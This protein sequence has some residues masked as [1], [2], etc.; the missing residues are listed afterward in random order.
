MR[1]MCELRWR[2]DSWGRAWVCWVICVFKLKGYNNVNTTRGRVSGR[3]GMG[4]QLTPLPPLPL[5]PFCESSRLT[6]FKG[7][8]HTPCMS[9]LSYFAIFKTR[10]AKTESSKMFV[11]I[12]VGI[13]FGCVAESGTP[14]S[15]FFLLLFI[16]FFKLLQLCC[17]IIV[18]YSGKLA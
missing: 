5:P 17:G 8:T 4:G 2:V 11:M 1:I 18:M 3:R 7:V 6:S 9:P 14:I 12:W 13:L 16:I 10:K 15:C